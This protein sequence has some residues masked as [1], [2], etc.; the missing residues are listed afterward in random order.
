[1]GQFGLEIGLTVL[2]VAICA[3]IVYSG[4]WLLV[5][6]RLERE[7]AELSAYAST[8]RDGCPQAILTFDPDGLIRSVNPA[9]EKLTGFAEK[10][11]WGQ[12]V[13]RIIPDA[14]SLASGSRGALEVRRKDQ[15]MV[16]VRYEAARSKP[17]A[18]AS[19]HLFLECLLRDEAAA[20]QL[21]ASTV[22]R[23]VGRIAS[24]FEE[25]VTTIDGYAELALHASSS[26]S[27][28]R[29]DLEQIVAASHRA[30]NLTRN[31][32]V[33]TGKQIIAAE[34]LDLNRWVTDLYPSLREVCS[35]S[36][37]LDLQPI[38]WRIHGNAEFLKQVLF[39]ICGRASAESSAGN[40]AGGRDARRVRIRTSAQ[41]LTETRTVYGRALTPGSYTMLTISDS[42]ITLDA[43]AKAQ[44][45]EP[46]YL[47]RS[48]VGVE[49][50]PIYGMVHS[51]RGGIDV[52][53]DPDHGTSFEIWLPSTHSVPCPN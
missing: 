5:R 6:K 25:L 29:P 47:D 7:N 17:P 51:L 39:L 44:L 4:R 49:L 18:R 45:F 32:V 12:S 20:R 26:E 31:L 50:S 24:E 16:R 3:A 2:V 19:I 14:L 21:T 27:P 13:L 33:F 38:P 35:S 43:E 53:S 11:L 48:A 34:P 1:M 8:L 40:S 42:G 9:L 46:F 41:W 36:I 15:S 10:D 23:V 37:D 28:S 22:E 52:I 30:L